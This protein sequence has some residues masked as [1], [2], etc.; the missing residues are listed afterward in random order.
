MALKSTQSILLVGALMISGAG[1][2][3][4]PE[5]YS[6]LLAPD[7][8]TWCGYRSQ[9]EFKSAADNAQP[10]VTARITYSGAEITEVI[11]QVT[12]QSGDWLLVDRYALATDVVTVRRTN[13]FAQN[14]V[15]VVQE[16][17]IRGG[18]VSAF[19]VVEVS[20]LDGIKTA[21][22]SNL[23]FPDVKVVVALSASPFVRIADEMRRNS[24]GKLCRKFD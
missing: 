20:T 3:P 5:N 6:V 24:L 15:Q 7:E 9:S 12:P 17:A 23:D 2:A 11:H 21:L 10:E 19:H 8:S 1:A 22:P 4:E 18:T 14:Q 16:A 13:L